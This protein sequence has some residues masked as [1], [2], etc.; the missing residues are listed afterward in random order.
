MS[1]LSPKPARRRNP[2]LGPRRRR[3]AFAVTTSLAL[4]TLAGGHRAQ[5]EAPS[6]D[7][8]VGSGVRLTSP[9]GNT[10]SIRPRVM[11]LYQRDMPDAGDAV[12]ALT[13]RRARLV[14]GHTLKALHLKSKLEIAMSS[15][16]L[17]FS[18][19][20]P[21][22]T[23]VLTWSVAWQRW[24]DLRVKVGQ[25]KL[26]YSR[27]RVISS[28][29]L[30]LVDRSAVQGEFT[31]DRD[32]GVELFSKDLFGL[33]LLRYVV[34]VYNGEGRDVY[35]LSSSPPLL[36][37][38]LEVLPFG[39]FDDYKE[40]DLKRHVRPKLSVGVAGA[41]MQGALRDRG[42]LGSAPSDG[43]TTDHAMMTADLHAKWRGASLAVE[44]HKRQS[45]R[46]PGDAGPE[47]PGRSGWGVVATLGWLLPVQQ[48]V[49]ICGRFGQIHGDA[50]SALADLRE[51]GGGLS[52]YLSGH[53]NKLQAD[54]FQ[55]TRDTTSEWRARLQFQASL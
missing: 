18:G 42:V 19:G 41:W 28:G 36:V 31:L 39:R 4:A 32:I 27:Q 37:A 44:A 6:V 15:R 12:H 10:L 2:A 22:Q 26:G 8:R 47:V 3:L 14:F 35:V 20:H 54:V 17:R 33:D 16:D 21:R 9:S 38:R 29:N 50:G 55:I 48:D 34:G 49:E 23:P 5:A 24:R 45:T 43:G 1:P 11:M 30:Q 13:L 46:S 25:F 53:A 40:A 52:W 7:H 51:L